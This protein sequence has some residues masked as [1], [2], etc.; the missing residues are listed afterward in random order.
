MSSDRKASELLT[1]GGMFL[2]VGSLL[3]DGICV[4]TMI[5]MLRPWQPWTPIIQ[6]LLLSLIPIVIGGT[7]MLWGIHKNGAV[8]PNAPTAA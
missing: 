1:T 4:P 3:F 6:L 7:A 8:S 2:L 5:G